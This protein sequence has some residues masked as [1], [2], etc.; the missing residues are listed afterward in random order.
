MGEVVPL[1]V[2]ETGAEERPVL[3]LDLG[4]Q[5]AQLI[6]RRVRE[7][8]VYS[9]LVPHS[10]TAA[11]ARARNPRALVLSG[12]PAS[13]YAEGAPKVDP[14]LF[15]L[16]V[17]SLG[18][19]YGMQLMAQEL[20][21]SVDRTGVSEFGKTEVRADAGESALFSGLPEEQTGW[22]S[23]RDSVTAPPEGARVTAGSPAAPI[24]AF[25]APERG[26]YGVQFHPEVVHTP[27]GQEL[28]KNFLYTVAGA[29][30]TWTAA[31][32]IEEQ[33]ER[34]RAQVGSQRVLCALSGGVD[35]AVA[36][37]LVH[38]AVGEQLVCVFVDH[39]FLR[40]DEA[41]QVVETFEGH[42]HVP[43]VHV[44]AQARF[45]SRLDGVADPEEK[46]KAVGEEFIRVFEEESNRLGKI[47]Y[48]VQGTLYSDVIESGGDAA[49]AA[50]IKSH[51]NVG[52][53][54]KEMEMELVEPLRLLF[55]DE[56]RRVGEEL[57]LPERMVWRQPFPGP[58]LAIR[59]I[60][61]VTRERLEI[62]READSILQEE[63]RRAGLYRELW[64]S[65]AVLPAIRS[66]GVQGDERTYGYPVVVRAVTS[67]DAMT[68]DWARLPYDLLET[69]SSRIVNEVP[70]VNRVVLDITSK[71]PSTIEWE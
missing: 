16:G 50:T 9:E 63:I 53:L 7:C 40:K 39:G 35:S 31:A 26:L 57:G 52:G 51:H 65:F 20:G 5:Y 70:A 10:I 4:G 47:R 56:V 25:E 23:H 13:V 27:H 42:F 48:L 36:A 71:P 61:E 66:V 24:A 12:G 60:G 43:L 69:I 8:R 49:L 2:A 54:P 34:I 1:P 38:K 45:L 59:I 6:A 18:I 37:L 22:M 44:D 33:V 58:G 46:R 68:A 17:P 14:E 62:L 64:Q 21:G 67:D 55:K 29:P 30:P 32:V 15:S 3:V 28:L 19:C 41:A 11:E